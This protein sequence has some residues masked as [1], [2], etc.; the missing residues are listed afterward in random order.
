[1]KKFNDRILHNEEFITN[2]VH[3]ILELDENMII[4]D[5]DVDIVKEFITE[6]IL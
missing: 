2:K 3:D 1:M 5:N 6:N 4:L